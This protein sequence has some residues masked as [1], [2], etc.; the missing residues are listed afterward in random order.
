MVTS[1]LNRLGGHASLV[2]ELRV[3]ILKFLSTVEAL[4][5]Q[6]EVTLDHIKILF[7]GLMINTRV[8]HD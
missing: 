6:F 5:L 3:A 7:I 2:T 8:F 4:S 1:S